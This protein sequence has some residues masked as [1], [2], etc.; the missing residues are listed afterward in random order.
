MIASL[1]GILKAK[2]PTELLLDVNGVGYAVSIPLS[3]FEKIGA[4]NSP[5][6]L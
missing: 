6:T 4:L 1:T 5:A 3:T 2:S